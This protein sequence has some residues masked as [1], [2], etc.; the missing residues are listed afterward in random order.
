MGLSGCRES[1]DLLE[2]SKY[3]WVT[4]FRIQS[5]WKLCSGIRTGL[6]SWHCQGC[7]LQRN[8]L[9]SIPYGH[10]VG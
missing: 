1:L 9:K 8:V 5:F 10:H 4:V 3:Q 7:A 6:R 2:G